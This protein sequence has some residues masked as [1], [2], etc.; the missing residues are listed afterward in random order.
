MRPALLALILSALATQ[1]MAAES[2]IVCRSRAAAMSWWR[3][4][5][6]G[7][8]PLRQT[9]RC[10]A[11]DGKWRVVDSDERGDLS[12]IRLVPANGGRRVRVWSHERLGDD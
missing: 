3:G 2:F 5:P 9:G 10:F 12:A 7:R 1:A 6:G 11:L 4:S 8:I